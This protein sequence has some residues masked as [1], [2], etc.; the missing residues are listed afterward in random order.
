MSQQLTLGINPEEPENTASAAGGN[1]EIEDITARNNKLL[2][3]YTIGRCN[4]PHAGHI[5]LFINTIEIART[6]KKE[7][8]SLTTRVIFFLGSGPNGGERTSKDP[9]DFETKKEVIEY[10][11]LN[12]DIKYTPYQSDGTG[13]YKIRKK[14]Y[15]LN[16]QL[17][18]PTVQ[19]AAEVRLL[20]TENNL[21]E[22]QSL[23]VVGDKDGDATKLK[24]MP[25][26]FN[27]SVNDMFPEILVKSEIIPIEPI[28]GATG[29]LSATAIREIAWD[30]LDVSDF[31]EKTN[32]FYGEMSEDVYDGIKPYKPYNTNRTSNPLVKPKSYK[33]SNPLVVKTKSYR[34]SNPLVKKPGKGGSRLKGTKKVTKKRLKKE[35]KR[36]KRRLTKGTKKRIKRRN[37]N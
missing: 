7:N 11:L 21:T 17:V 12:R 1:L 20:N 23:L 5:Q 32:N 2:M 37:N 29:N 34:T 9:L 15:I 22:I 27:K 30:S 19:L 33:T 4:P 3:I 36:T 18:T 25:D 16:K 8:P 6:A 10:L 31:M 26:S 24:Y 14:D 28:Q 13:D 35:Q